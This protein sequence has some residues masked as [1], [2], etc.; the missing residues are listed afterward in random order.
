M[1][2][3]AE[4]NIELDD[5]E[6]FKFRACSPRLAC[7]QLERLDSE[8]ELDSETSLPNFS[9]RKHIGQEDGDQTSQGGEKDT[10]HKRPVP[11]VPSPN[12]LKFDRLGSGHISPRPDNFRLGRSL[13]CRPRYKAKES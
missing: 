11:R 12:R 3:E 6:A 7:K 10:L 8:E 1:E 9:P 13:S 5:F 4:E 2:S